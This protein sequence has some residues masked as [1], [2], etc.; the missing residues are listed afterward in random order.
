[1]SE[2]DIQKLAQPIIRDNVL[3]NKDEYDALFYG[4]SYNPNA[5]I[6]LNEQKLERISK[7]ETMKRA[8]RRQTG[9]SFISNVRTS[10]RKKGFHYGRNPVDIK[11]RQNNHRIV[12]LIALS[13]GEDASYFTRTAY[14]E[15]AFNGYARAGTSSASGLFQF[16]ESTWLCTLKK[17]GNRETIPDIYAISH[18]RNGCSVSDS[19]TRNRLLSLRFNSILNTQMAMAHTDDNRRVIRS[20]GL[21]PTH[22]R[23]YALHFFGEGDG[24]RFLTANPFSKAAYVTPRAANSNRSVFYRG[25]EA[26]MV[27]QVLQDFE[28]L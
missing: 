17:H 16:T 3:I 7:Y 6:F 25:G 22:G 14:R 9:A 15:S 27:W 10:V 18:G 20:L 4:L 2:T 12:E 11:I 28:R 19:G 24:I 23:L 13:K 21:E 1:M 5:R 26:L 8:S